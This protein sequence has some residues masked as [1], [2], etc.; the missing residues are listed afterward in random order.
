M[1]SGSTTSTWKQGYLSTATEVSSDNSALMCNIRRHEHALE[2][3]I[4]GICRTLMAV[5]RHLG[6]ELPNEGE[7][8][9]TFD[10]SIIADTAA[11]KRQ[12]M[13][14]V[15]AGLMEPWEYRAKWYGEDEVMARKR[16]AALGAL[17]RT[18]ASASSSVCPKAAGI[19]ATHSIR[20][21]FGLVAAA[22]LR[23]DE[24]EKEPAPPARAG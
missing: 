23:R 22:R 17:T 8:R 16:A 13:E 6:V 21:A 12:D 14:E 1:A 5:G 10:D 11:E 2:G 7:V 20:G 18:S 3:S 9:V 4:S 19:W 15:A 24:P